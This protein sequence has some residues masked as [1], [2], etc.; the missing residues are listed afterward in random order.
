MKLIVKTMKPR[1]PLVG[2]SRRR[3]AGSHR[4][5]RGG[6]RQEAE[7]AVRRELGTF[8]QRSP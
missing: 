8:V 1:N 7:R 2:P 6:M 4:A 3:L 5:S